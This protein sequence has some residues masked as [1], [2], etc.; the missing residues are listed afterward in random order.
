MPI[1]GGPAELGPIRVIRPEQDATEC[2]EERA[3]E[4]SHE[5]SLAG[6]LEGTQ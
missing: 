5:A 3:G 4:M 2:E 6:G 1:A